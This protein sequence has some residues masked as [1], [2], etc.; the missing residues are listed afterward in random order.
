MNIAK[1]LFAFILSIS[2]SAF[3]ENSKG[4]FFGDIDPDFIKNYLSRG[5]WVTPTYSEDEKKE[6]LSKF[7]HVDPKKEIPS[8][9]LEEALLFFYYHRIKLANRNYVSIINYKPHSKNARFFL[10]DMNTG[11]VEN[12]HVAHGRNS[13]PDNDGI[14]TRFS[15]K[16][17]SLMSSLG[18]MMTQEEYRGSNGASLRLKGV[19]ESNFR[20]RERN[21]VMHGSN[22]V[23]AK[24]A[25]QGRSWGC[26]AVSHSY[27]KALIKKIGKGSL[28]LAG[29]QNN[30]LENLTQ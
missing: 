23:S 14:A 28:I 27:I 21:I 26:P 29:Y 11:E 6:I 13:D 12:Y 16:N 3:A 25:K 17:G 24:R 10:I 19:S 4:K 9:L 8:S 5:V 1:T 2:C 22:Y 18:F 30:N 7:S 15:N 20:A